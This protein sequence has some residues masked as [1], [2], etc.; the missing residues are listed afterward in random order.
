MLPRASG[1]TLRHGHP[2]GGHGR[3]DVAD[4]ARRRHGAESG[5]W[6]W[7]WRWRWREGSQAGAERMAA[8]RS[9]GWAPLSDVVD[10]GGVGPRSVR[11]RVGS[12]PWPGPSPAGRRRAGHQPGTVGH[13]CRGAPWLLGRGERSPRHRSFAASRRTLRVRPRPPVSRR[14]PTGCCTGLLQLETCRR[15]SSLTE[16]AGR[17]YTWAYRRRCVREARS[18]PADRRSAE[19]GCR[20]GDGVWRS[21]GLLRWLEDRSR[22][23]RVILA[24]DP[25]PSCSG[26]RPAAHLGSDVYRR[27]PAEWTSRRPALAQ[28]RHVRRH[29]VCRVRR[30]LREGHAHRRFV[31]SVRRPT[32]TVSTRTTTAR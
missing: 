6:R 21:G 8:G 18:S 13:A 16:V 30:W 25:R 1:A 3:S 10:C 28:G 26:D 14:P 4:A 17:H 27:G 2:A 22:R 9:S 23:R 11:C 19:R 15:R 5:R 29:R 20:V 31:S 12:C 7:R 32:R 24:R